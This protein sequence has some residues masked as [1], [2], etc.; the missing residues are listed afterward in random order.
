MV[1]L[2]GG[3]HFDN[4][5]RLGF[6]FGSQDGCQ[7]D[8]GFKHNFTGTPTASVYE[9]LGQVLY[10]ATIGKND[11]G[12]RGLTLRTVEQPATE[13]VLQDT[14]MALHI[15][16]AAGIP[17]AMACR[18]VN[19]D[20]FN[21]VKGA[22]PALYAS[23]TPSIYVCGGAASGSGVL[24]VVRRLNA[25][26]DAWED[27]A[28]MSTPRRLCTATNLGGY[29]YVCGGETVYGVQLSTKEFSQVNATERFNPLGGVWETLPPMPTARA[30]CAATA[31]H[32]L[33]YVC[34]GR[35]SETVG[36]A[37]ERFDPGTMR[38]ERL[39]GMPTAR[40]GC[41]AVSVGTLVCVLG[42]KDIGSNVC[43]ATEAF[44][45]SCGRWMELPEML[46]ARSAFA[47]GSVG[48]IVY[49]AGGFNGFSGT[50]FCE[51]LDP[52]GSGW[53]TIAPLAAP[54]V[55]GAATVAG[56]KLFVFG[57]KASDI[58]EAA[59]SESLDPSTRTWTLL[60]A[61]PDPQVYCAGAAA[62]C[63]SSPVLGNVAWHCQYR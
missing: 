43:G 18:A 20:F 58:E 16:V 39:P 26:E 44:D 15:V 48:G 53:E 13:L 31:S 46:Q 54:R 62:I 56:G 61:L 35:I 14:A 52:R 4:N 59:A 17:A 11:D 2:G 1:A 10:S 33:L 3:I 12:L 42:G 40:S 49:V 38:W 9:A 47:A 36:N 57:G 5:S 7:H 60:P 25:G 55:G 6:G 24:N 37:V 63:A 41:S 23:A 21:R 8:P 30:G 27:V 34:G 28:K 22:L 45:V 32:G 19:A 50:D 51:C 29:I